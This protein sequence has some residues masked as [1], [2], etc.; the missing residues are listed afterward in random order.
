MKHFALAVVSLCVGSVALAADE[1]QPP[2]P[3]AERIKEL[4][5]KLEEP[6]RAMSDEKE[7]PPDGAW[8]TFGYRWHSNEMP[9]SRPFSRTLLDDGP[10]IRAG[11]EPLLPPSSRFYGPDRLWCQPSRFFSLRPQ[12]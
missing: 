2:P 9:F 4:V 3:S 8:P 11:C 12:S 1:K 6:T 5:K 7:G 10:L